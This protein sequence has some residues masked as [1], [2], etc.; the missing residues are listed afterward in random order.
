MRAPQK[1]LLVAP[2][3]IDHNTQKDFSYEWN[4]VYLSLQRS[5]CATDFFDFMTSYKM[6]GQ[7]TMQEALLS[8]VK[9]THPDIIIFMLV[10]DEFSTDFVASLKNTFKTFWFMMDDS[11]RKD[12]VKKWAPCFTAFSTIDT[13]GKTYYEKSGL[14]NSVL[15]LDGVNTHLFENQQ[16]ERNIDVSFIGS[17][18][19]Y[20]EWII[21]Q[22]KKK[23]INVDTYGYGWP[24]G[25]INTTEMI[26]LFNRSKIS[27]NLS[28]SVSWDAR[29]FF[30]HSRGLINTLRSRKI[31]EQIKGRHF[32]IP[33]CG[34]MQISFYTTGLGLIYDIDK[35]IVLYNDATHLAQLIHY[36]LENAPDR[37]AIATNGYQRTIHC[38]DY[39]TRFNTLF[40][41]MGWLV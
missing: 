36:Y 22:L 26:K 31:S 12:Y 25:P 35:E 11:W 34:A 27:L 2:K 18:H 16:V 33:A 4:H 20:R 3:Y 29:Y 40:Q 24:T 15:F 38:H 7:L 8:Q 39:A 14:M 41:Q 19:P 9:A 6:G 13:C 21:Q 23:G 10:T 37:E 17:W 1:I 5:F 32:E 28:N 30:T